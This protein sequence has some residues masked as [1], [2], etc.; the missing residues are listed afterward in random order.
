[1]ETLICSMYQ[2]SPSGYLILCSTTSQ[3]LLCVSVHVCLYIV[4]CFS[5]GI[6]SASAC[7]LCLYIYISICFCVYVCILCRLF[8]Y[9]IMRLYVLVYMYVFQYVF[10]CVCIS[11]CLMC[12]HMCF[13]M[14]LYVC[15]QN[16]IF[17]FVFVHIRMLY[18]YDDHSFFRVFVHSHFTC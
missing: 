9:A 15:L 16:C 18:V 1:M 2:Q 3:F 8:E 17:V 12:M 4:Q 11:M 6:A 7:V 10:V 14:H 5:I 13:S